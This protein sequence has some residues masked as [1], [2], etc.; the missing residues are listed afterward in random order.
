MIRFF[1][2]GFP[3]QYIAIFL[4][5]MLLWGR[6]FFDPCSMP[7]PHGFVPF[8]SLL[9]SLLSTTPIIA[10]ILGFILV[11]VSAYL[12]NQLL[13]VND[14][15]LKNSSLAG[16]LFV[17]LMSF[18]PQLLILQPV[19][20]SI[21]FLLLIVKQL[22]NSYNREDPYDLV[23]SAGFFTAIG[24]LFYFPFL[25]FILF[26]FFSFIFF[27]S[28][29]WREWVSSFLGFLTPFVF[30]SVY[31]FWN[32]RLLSKVIDYFSALEVEMSWKIF[33]NTFFTLSASV[34]ILFFLYCFFNGFRR[35]T[36]KT[37]EIRRKTLL[38]TWIMFFAVIS[39][40]FSSN[41]FFYHLEILF[42][43]FSGFITI[44][45]MQIKRFFWQELF[46][47]L[48]LISILLNNLIFVFN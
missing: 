39:A 11:M 47:L 43:T 28:A 41:L 3:V 6:A 25:L 1:K 30:F 7:A 29:S 32:D 48:F 23:Y 19:N 10:V 5:G 42:I 36:E 8:Y 18:H 26:I 37:I 35:A 12:L 34:I 20:I 17:I 33:G 13:T 16:F 31:Y 38:L 46:I 14:V 4:I 40:P 9:F 21:F 22:F 45:L 44:Y 27:R 2:S 15:V 24:S